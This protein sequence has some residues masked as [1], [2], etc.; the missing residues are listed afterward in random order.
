M[1]IVKGIIYPKVLWK[2][3]SDHYKLDDYFFIQFI[4]VCITTKKLVK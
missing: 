4:V 1:Q 2:L 3:L